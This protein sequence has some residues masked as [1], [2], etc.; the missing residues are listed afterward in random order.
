MKNHEFENENNVEERRKLQTNIEKLESLL[1][2]KKASNLDKCVSTNI[3]ELCNQNCQTDEKGDALEKAIEENVKLEKKVTDL[4]DVLYGCPECGYNSCECNTFDEG[5]H[6][7]EVL[8]RL[9]VPPPSSLSTSWTPPP[10]PPCLK[11]GGINFG[12]SPSS[13]CF[14]CLP[15]LQSTFEP[16]YI[17]Q[18]TTPPGTPPLKKQKQQQK[19]SQ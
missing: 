16:N 8:E 13:E 12:P 18:S 2:A 9:T 7:D 11:C 4:L 5:D 19:S 14:V 15:E 1:T 10:T 6:S 3:V 17:S